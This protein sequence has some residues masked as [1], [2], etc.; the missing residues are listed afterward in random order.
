MKWN[1]YRENYRF[2]I[3]KIY[4]NPEECHDICHVGGRTY[5]IF[6]K[7]RSRGNRRWNRKMSNW[8]YK[9]EMDFE[10]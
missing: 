6:V 8:N 9:E 7:H 5:D 4:A 2:W 3:I 1:K 10:R